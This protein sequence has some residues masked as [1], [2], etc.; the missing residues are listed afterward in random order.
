[1]TQAA[2]DRADADASSTRMEERVAAAW[3]ELL[4]AWA[5]GDRSGLSWE[6]N[7]R[8]RTTAG[9]AWVRE[10]R[11]ELNPRLLARHPDA[12]RMVVA[13]EL[14][15]CLAHRRAPRE[16][17]HGPT[18]RALM[19]AVGEAPRATHRL[20]VGDLAVRRRR[21]PRGAAPRAVPRRRGLWARLLGW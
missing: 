5:G 9:R 19:V 8:L 16:S 2:V 1:M 7:P 14:A 13:H 17:A 21:R 11:V 12:V 15:H 18:W 20:D 3:E 4:A 6:W 10:G